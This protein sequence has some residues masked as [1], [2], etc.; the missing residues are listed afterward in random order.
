M[1]KYLHLLHYLKIDESFT[2]EP[3]QKKFPQ[4]FEKVKE[5]AEQGEAIAQINLGELYDYNYYY[6]SN[7][8]SSHEDS[9]DYE[10]LDALYWYKKAADQENPKALDWLG[11][12]ILAV[13][14]HS[15]IREYIG[16]IEKKISTTKGE[17]F[18]I[19]EKYKTARK[20]FKAAA[21]LGNPSSLQQLYLMHFYGTNG[22]EKNPTLAQEYMNKY[23]AQRIDISLFA[24]NA[25]ES[26]HRVQ[27]EAVYWRL[28]KLKETKPGFPPFQYLDDLRPHLLIHPSPAGFFFDKKLAQSRFEE[29][30]NNRR[31]NLSMGLLD[32][33]AKYRKKGDTHIESKLCRLVTAIE[34][35]QKEYKT[36]GLMLYPYTTSKEV[37]FANL[38]FFAAHHLNNKT[39]FIS[40]G[41]GN[42]TLGNSLTTCLTQV[43]GEIY[44]EIPEEEMYIVMEAVD[45]TEM[46]IQ[47]TSYIRNNKF[48]Q[49]YPDLKPYII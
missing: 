44:K 34:G 15:D 39:Y 23:Q 19:Q 36:N 37:G 3:L 20:C 8:E 13:C 7:E 27:S 22:A 30:L 11:N 49:L 2:Q 38:P 9:S 40:I 31:G 12:H 35:F 43:A 16:S 46:L 42:V 28:L 32:L 1:K 24:G 18:E 17:K 10:D 47:E 25:A 29:I 48:L 21:D 14:R 45:R 6:V 26:L 33:V 5:R 41:E 4:L